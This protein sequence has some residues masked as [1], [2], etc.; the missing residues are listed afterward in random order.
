MITV[1]VS[2]L[3]KHL[4]S[5]EERYRSAN[6]WLN[7]GLLLKLIVSIHSAIIAIPAPTDSLNGK[8]T[9]V[10]S[11]ARGGDTAVGHTGSVCGKSALSCLSG[12]HRNS[13]NS[14]LRIEDCLLVQ[15]TE[16]SGWTL[17]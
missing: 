5:D 11:E 3:N 16:L 12:R 14:R 9:R 8:L 10:K 1:I 7:L 13:D 17:F 15:Y 6:R 2:G 4:S